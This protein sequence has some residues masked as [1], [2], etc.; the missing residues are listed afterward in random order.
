MKRFG[1]LYVVLL[2]SILCPMFAATSTGD[3]PDWGR[4]STA[5]FFSTTDGSSPSLAS[6]PSIPF[7]STSSMLDGSEPT[8]SI[9][10]S[11]MS[12]QGPQ[13]V[14]RDDNTGDPGD[15]P[16][17]PIGDMLLPLLLIALGYAAIRHLKIQYHQ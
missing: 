7:Y 8:K 4:E 9:I 1:L 12:P 10:G 5:V 11:N 6:T 3:M 16:V 17:T 13:R 14:D 15:S 2:S